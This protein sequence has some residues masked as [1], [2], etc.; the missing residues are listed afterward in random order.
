MRRRRCAAC[1][2]GLP[3]AAAGSCQRGARGDR[4][5]GGW[6]GVVTGGA[7]AVDIFA[8]A[9]GADD[10]Q[11]LD[12]RRFV[13]AEEALATERVRFVKAAAD[14]DEFVGGKRHFPRE[15]RVAFGRS[16]FL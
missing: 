7:W 11:A 5:D 14:D 8:G 16:L 3:P 10:Q 6:E 15:L 2:R 13:A 12:R 1:D 4:R 9:A